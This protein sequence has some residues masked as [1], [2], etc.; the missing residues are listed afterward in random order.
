[1][2]HFFAYIARM[3]Y[4]IRWNLMRNSYREN[5]AEHSLQTAMV[6]HALAILHNKA[7]GHV[8]E[9]NVLALAVYHECGEVITGDLPT[10]IKYYNPAIRD[11]YKSVEHIAEERMRSMLPDDMKDD[12]AP[13]ITGKGRDTE[14]WKLVK[15]ADRICA[16]LKC[17]EELRAGNEEFSRAA[18]SIKRLIDE[19]DS[20]AVRR[21]MRDFVP[22]FSLTLDELN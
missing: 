21:F 12:Y 11:A 2:H 1:M 3:R 17:L 5:I 16:Y 15:A 14:E 4:V 13:Y 19:I 7:G 22:S 10:P 8:D 20:D 9:K 6:A 18:D